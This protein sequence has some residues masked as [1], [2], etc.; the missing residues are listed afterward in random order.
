MIIHSILIPM[1]R[2]TFQEAAK[3]VR[4]HGFLI[5]KVFATNGYFR[6]TQLQLCRWATYYVKTLPKGIEIVIRS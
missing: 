6:F 4:A 2:F 1:D 5:K 3:W